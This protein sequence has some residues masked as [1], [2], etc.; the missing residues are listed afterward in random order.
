LGL[1][2]QRGGGEN[3]IMT[4]TMRLISK[5]EAVDLYK[6]ISEGKE[7]WLPWL[8]DISGEYEEN[9]YLAVFEDDTR[10]LVL[11]D[12]EYDF[13]E[14]FLTPQ[15]KESFEELTLSEEENF[16]LSIQVSYWMRGARK[17]DVF[18]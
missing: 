17:M 18:I 12:F 4:R 10:V 8:F 16:L 3:T 14:Y 15:M 1:D 6:R 13:V 9:Y 2:E 11:I 7:F 5:E